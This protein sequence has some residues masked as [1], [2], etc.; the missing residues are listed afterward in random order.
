MQLIEVET[1]DNI[2]S[3]VMK[4]IRSMEDSDKGRRRIGCFCVRQTTDREE[5]RRDCAVGKDDQLVC[6]IFPTDII[7]HLLPPSSTAA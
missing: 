2:I 3:R 1:I 6:F 4:M 5:T 7:H